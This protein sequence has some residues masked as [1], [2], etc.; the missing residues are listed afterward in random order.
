[1]SVSS[2]TG[3][4]LPDIYLVEDD[5]TLNAEMAELVRRFGYDVMAFTT[6]SAALAEIAGADRPFIV[7]TDVMMPEFTGHTLV[8]EIE[9]TEGA[10]YPHEV[11]MVS[12]ESGFEEALDAMSLGVMDFLPKPVDGARLRQVLD[13]AVERIAERLVETTARTKLEAGLTELR[14][15]ADKLARNLIGEGLNI[16]STD[17][18]LMPDNVMPFPGPDA[19][20][21]Q[22]KPRIMERPAPVRDLAPMED[23]HCFLAAIKLM[24]NMRRV[25]DRLFPIC[26]D[27]DPSF[28]ILLYVEEQ[29]LLGRQV[30]VTSACHAALIPQTTAMRKIDELVA[31]NILE[32]V[33]D[34]RDKRRILLRPNAEAEESLRRYISGALE[35]I[36]GAFEMNEKDISVRHKPASG[37]ARRDAAE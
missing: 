21:H 3:S 7:M 12:G 9:G 10:R 16:R 23:D 14:S 36:Y 4:P 18:P 5:P 32:R 26:A 31:N 33:P 19:M 8:K 11:I 6:P 1:M 30:S 13:R 2:N 35:Q 17:A 15:M 20:H 27:G 29:V 28:D 37:V 34:P 24:Q 22:P 25:R